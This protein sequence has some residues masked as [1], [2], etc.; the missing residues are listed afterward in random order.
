MYSRVFVLA[1]ILTRA[2]SPSS[3]DATIAAYVVLIRHA[4]VPRSHLA[5]ALH[6]SRREPTAP[7]SSSSSSSSSSASA[8]LSAAA[9]HHSHATGDPDDEDGDDG[10]AFNVD[11][12]ADAGADADADAGDLSAAHRTHGDGGARMRYPKLAAFATAVLARA[13]VTVVL[14]AVCGTDY[15]VL[16]YVV[17]GA[18]FEGAWHLWVDRSVAIHVAQS[19]HLPF[20][21]PPH[22]LFDPTPLA[23]ALS[24]KSVL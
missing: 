9:S 22:V 6:S 10:A 13:N 14:E 17:S 18:C 2:L 20:L 16:G 4:H 19:T 12:D 11:T 8:S 15:A 5:R 1:L 7:T 3:I 24:G 23:A 21:H